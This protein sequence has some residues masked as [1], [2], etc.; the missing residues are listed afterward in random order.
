MLRGFFYLVWMKQSLLLLP[1]MVLTVVATAQQIP[2]VDSGKAL[3]H[4][5]ELEDSKK[6][7][8]AIEELLAIPERDTNYILSRSRLTEL[9]YLDDQFERGLTTCDEVLQNPSKYRSLMLRTKGKIYRD[10]KDFDKAIA[11]FQSA[12]K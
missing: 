10:Q 5:Q 9:Y 2:L 4:A 3:K 8:L 6:Y 7:A 11:T 1:A 12:L